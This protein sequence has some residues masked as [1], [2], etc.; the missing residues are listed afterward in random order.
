MFTR[1]WVGTANATAAGWGNLGGA[2]TQLLVGS[3]LFPLFK[4]IYN[5]DAEKSWRT[6]CIFPAMIGLITSYCVIKYTDDNPKG[7][8]S[9]L[10]KQN[11]M[12]SVSVQ[13][14]YR[15][16][17]M[18]INTWL[19]FVQY[20]CCFGVEITM[21]NA[22]SHYFKEE[23][24]LSTEKAAAISSIFGWMNLFARGLGGFMSDR[25]STRYGT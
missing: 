24:D 11:Q 8:F 13:E 23:F 19:V 10:K 2:T 21:N 5:G 4:T 20:A 7:N 1:D 16:G 6:V 18:N 25:A 3:M 12:K 9:K 14:N 17:T 15:K 22:A